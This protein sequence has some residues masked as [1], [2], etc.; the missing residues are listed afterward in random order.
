[1]PISG[2]VISFGGMSAAQVQEDWTFAAKGLPGKN[3]V[4]ISGPP[5]W[6]LKAVRLN[7]ADV[8]DSGIDVKRNQEV[9]GIEIE[10]TNHPASVSGTVTNTRGDAPADYT[11]VVFARDE[12]RWTPGTRYIMTARPDQDGRFKVSPAPPG[13][14]L[15]AALEFIEPGQ[16][17]DPDFL[18]QIRDRATSF[19]L[20][21]GEAKTLNL[22]LIALP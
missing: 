14:Y 3:R 10:M 9:H 2:V 1:M 17:G 4:M 21:D 7:G 5:G 15:A 18:K 16:S 12:Q 20:G 19:S 22:K 6:S 8:T 11:V 13:D